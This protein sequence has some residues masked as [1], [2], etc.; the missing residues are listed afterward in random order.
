VVRIT[1]WYRNTV[2]TGQRHASKSYL[3]M[4]AF[5]LPRRQWLDLRPS[6]G[7]R[8]DEKTR[9]MTGEEANRDDPMGEGSCIHRSGCD[10]D[11]GVLATLALSLVSQCD[12]RNTIVTESLPG[13]PQIT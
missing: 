13:R 5:P 8:G 7:D 9:R 3:Q 1:V 10:G 6:E 11:S 4:M 12:D 2:A